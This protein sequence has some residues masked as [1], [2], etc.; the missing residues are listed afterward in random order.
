MPHPV[1]VVLKAAL[2]FQSW[3]SVKTATK[4][5]TQTMAHIGFAEGALPWMKS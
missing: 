3:W 4:S 2:I 5:F 1:D